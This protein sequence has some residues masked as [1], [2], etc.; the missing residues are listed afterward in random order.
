LNSGSLLDL[1]M[2]MVVLPRAVRS[3]RMGDGI[4]VHEGLSTYKCVSCWMQSWVGPE[5]TLVA[6]GLECDMVVPWL[7]SCYMPEVS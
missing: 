3:Q 2:W 1:L 5:T 7:W 6:R 4:R